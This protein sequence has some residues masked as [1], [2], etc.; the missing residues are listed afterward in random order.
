MNHWNEFIHAISRTNIEIINR[1][2]EE[3]RVDPSADN[4]KAIRIASQKGHLDIV[5][6]L[7]EDPRVDPSAYNN[8]AIKWA[9][10]NGHFDIVNRLLEDPRVD[11]SSEN[12]EAIRLASRNGHFN[13][14]TRLMIDQRVTTNSDIALRAI[15]T[16]NNQSRINSING[17]EDIPIIPRTLHYIHQSQDLLL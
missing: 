13:I 16:L 14:V 11:P 9:S 12:N 17:R 5:N 3:N 10:Q 6:R 2:L 4:N 15:Q 8:S 1:L 7:L